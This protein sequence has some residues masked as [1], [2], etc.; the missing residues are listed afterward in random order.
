MALQR[1]IIG[2]PNVGSRP[3]STRAGIPAENIP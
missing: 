3:F 2:P 1:G